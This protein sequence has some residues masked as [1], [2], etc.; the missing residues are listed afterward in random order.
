MPAWKSLPC[1]LTPTHI[2]PRHI[3][4]KTKAAKRQGRWQFAAKKYTQ[5]GDRARAIRSLVR[6]GDAERVLLYAS[7][8][9]CVWGGVVWG[10]VLALCVC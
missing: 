9:V 1:D 2:T 10:K 6:G 7:A 5:A 3:P 8:F 4:N